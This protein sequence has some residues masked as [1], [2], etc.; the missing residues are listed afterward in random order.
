ME[1]QDVR[2]RSRQQYLGKREKERLAIFRQQVAEENEER[3]SNPKLSQREIAEFDKNREILSIAEAR[4]RIDDH[5]EGYAL[6]DD[7]LTEKNKIDR[8]RKEK[9]LNERYVERDKYGHEIYVTEQDQWEAE[10]TQKAKAQIS[11]AE[12]LNEADYGYVFDDTQK[13]NFVLD[14]T[15]TNDKR[16]LTAEERVLQQKLAVAEKEAA[17][18]EETRKRLPVYAYREEFLAAVKQYKQLIIVGETGSGKTTQ[19]PQYLLASGDHTKIAITQ[20]RRVAAMSVA[21]RV[22]DEMGVRLGNEVGYSIRFEEKA[23]DKT[24]IH[25]MTD[26]H[27]LKA[28][29]TD[30]ELSEYSAIMIDEAH[31]RSLNTDILLGLLKDL[32]RFRSDLSLIISSATLDAQKFASFYDN[33]PIFNIPGRAFKVDH[34]YS[35]QPESNYVA[36]ALTTV[37]QIHVSQPLPAPDVPGGDILV[38]LTGQDEIESMAESLTETAKR[39]GKQAPEL[40]IAPIFAS[41]DSAM[42]SKIFATTPHG[43]RK[44]VIAT[45][46]AE[47]SITIEGISYVVDCGYQ[48]NNH[49]SPKTRM[50]SLVIEPCSRAAANQRAGRAGRSREGHCF[51]LFTK[52][53]MMSEMDPSTTPE[54]LRTNIVGVVLSLKALGINDL[55]QFDFLDS[56]DPQSIISALEELYALGC[57]SD[58]GQLTRVGRQCAEL[59]LQAVESRA[60]IA[61]GELGCSD[62]VITILSMLGQTSALF[63]KPKEARIHADS[64]HRRFAPGRVA[65]EGGDHIQLLRIYNE[66]AES[67]YSPIWAKENF[68]QIRQL[69]VAR[70]IRD[71]LVKMCDRIEVPVTSCGPSDIPK[72]LRA[73]TAGFF[74]NA[75]T[76][77]RDAYRTVKQNMGVALHP[78]SVLREE[79]PRWLV[80]SEIMLTSK[81]FMRN[82]FPIDPAWLQEVAPHFWKQGELPAKQKNMPRG[83]GMVS[84]SKI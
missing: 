70:D 28:M 10:Q 17:T 41:M 52:H 23:G 78:T 83:Q 55:L 31:E 8:S 54:I 62:E 13:I 33:C 30:P 46:I 44:V 60:L 35:P 18:I 58:Q 49:F 15:A 79:K 6:P 75:A 77:S 16:R 53:A 71:Q 59:P 9:A 4:L 63:L 20:P 7:Y 82:C 57:L 81:E 32:A 34:Y 3:R 11:R 68:L 5:V 64:A 36:A 27:L 29:Q 38:F 40:I 72:I 51:R 39:L 76:M 80:F 74:M 25:Y 2:E 56:P 42:Q 12:R 43:C 84:G 1:M 26:G 50:S 69:Q 65:I 19:L 47:T 21:K 67:D 14:G 22:S 66:W 24:R 61:S 48:K 37:F 73:L 45:N